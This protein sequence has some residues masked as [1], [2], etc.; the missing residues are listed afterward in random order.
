M[1]VDEPEGIGRTM[2][3][4]PDVAPSSPPPVG[5]LPGTGALR[6]ARLPAFAPEAPER[7]PV[8]TAVVVAFSVSIE[9]A[10][11]AIVAV[12]RDPVVA[13]H[14][15]R[16][17][18]RTARSILRVVEPRLSRANALELHAQLRTAIRETGTMRDRDVLPAALAL[19]PA[20]P[21]TA[22]ARAEVEALLLSGR[23]AARRTAR[24]RTRRPRRPPLLLIER[25]ADVL[26]GSFSRED[27]IGGVRRLARARPPF[28]PPR[29]ARA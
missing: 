17:G 1:G 21:G 7:T 9:R 25:F 14:E 12:D 20:R 13:V 19:L 6:D 22:E 23:A 27:L 8:A 26:P 29:A 18:V 24:A 15:L 3:R 4:A 11:D 2:H 16:R 28:S 10:L 5:E